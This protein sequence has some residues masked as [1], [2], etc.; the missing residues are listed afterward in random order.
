MDIWAQVSLKETFWFIRCSDCFYF[1][2]LRPSQKI[3]FFLMQENFNRSYT[4]LWSNDF[5]GWFFP[6]R[7]TPRKHPYL[8]EHRGKTSLS[9]PFFGNGIFLL[10]IVLWWPLLGSFAW[11]WTSESNAR[12][13][14][15]C[16]CKS[17]NCNGWWWFFED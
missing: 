14:T 11:L 5:E 4:C 2:V 16:L 9:L 8:Q 15:T 6:C 10:N 17:C 13:F 3:L 1:P 7:S 12:G